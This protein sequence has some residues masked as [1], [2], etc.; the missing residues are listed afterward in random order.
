MM[1][2][3]ACM[4]M[5][6]VVFLGYSI[7]QRRMQFYAADLSYS[8]A[9]LDSFMIMRTFLN[10]IS[11]VYILGPNAEARSGISVLLSG[12]AKSGQHPSYQPLQISHI[13]H[14]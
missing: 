1:M 11:L 4:Q 6:I 12:P 5:F 3:N 13:N 2:M 7:S 9:L 8:F 10:F 14:P